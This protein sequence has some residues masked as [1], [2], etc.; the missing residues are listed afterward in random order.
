MQLRIVFTQI[1]ETTVSVQW[2][3]E[4]DRVEDLRTGHR[5]PPVQI[6]FTRSSW[7][8]AYAYIR[9]VLIPAKTEIGTESLAGVLQTPASIHSDVA[10]GLRGALEVPVQSLL[11]S[12]GL[13]R[14]P[15]ADGFSQ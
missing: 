11:G 13:E 12:L 8:S 9:L 10:N 15:L 14:N 6:H 2:T 5:L 7:P 1:R 4:L 3:R